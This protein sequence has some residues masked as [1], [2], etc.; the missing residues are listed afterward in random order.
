MHLRC[1]E[2]TFFDSGDFALSRA[3][4]DSVTGHQKTGKEHP[5]PENISHLSSPVPGDSNLNMD[6]NTS[7][8][9]TRTNPAEVP[10]PI[11]QRSQHEE[12]GNSK[13][14]HANKE[15]KA[16]NGHVLRERSG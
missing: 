14:T 12:E 11:D 1:Q 9:R 7:Q 10:S 15:S 2:R 16:K 8:Y 5:R 6:A 4:D 13:F 3:T